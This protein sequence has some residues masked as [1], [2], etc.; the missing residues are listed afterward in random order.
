MAMIKLHISIRNKK[1]IFTGMRSECDEIWISHRL[2]ELISLS[3]SKII[4]LLSPCIHTYT[5]HC[6]F[7]KVTTCFSLKGLSKIIFWSHIINM[8]TK[9]AAFSSSL[10][11]ATKN[12]Q[13]RVPG[14][15]EN[16]ST[17]LW[18]QWWIKDL[19]ENLDSWLTGTLFLWLIKPF[20]SCNLEI[21]LY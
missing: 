18:W 17:C 7:I 16:F 21:S 1:E 2:N 10:G 19:W 5:A 13:R 9:L 14:S 12:I 3:S 15:L 8:C 4:Y 6:F 11:R 20:S